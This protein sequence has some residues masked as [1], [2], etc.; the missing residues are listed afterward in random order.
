MRNCFKF[1]QKKEK[2][3]EI[4]AIKRL[5][6]SFDEKQK[7]IRKLESKLKEVDINDPPVSK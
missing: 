2:A 7:L 1:Y 6:Q 3:L 4:L 5:I